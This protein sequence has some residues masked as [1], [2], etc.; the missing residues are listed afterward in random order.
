MSGKHPPIMLR[1]RLTPDEWE[2]I[3]VRAIRA[4]MATTDYVAQLIRDGIRAED[5][6]SKKVRAT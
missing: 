2:D 5:G 6:H 4:N 3:R 1:A